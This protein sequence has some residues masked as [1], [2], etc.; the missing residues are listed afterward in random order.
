MKT[1]NIKISEIKEREDNPNKMNKSEMEALKKSIVKFG[2]LQPVLI[3]QENNLIDGHQRKKAYEELGK[4]EIPT[5]QLDLTEQSDKILLSQIMNKVKGSN[6]PELDIND[7]K[8]LLEDFGME[9][10]TDSLAVSEQEVLNLINSMNKEEKET[11]EQ[12]S[13]LGKH[14][15]ECPK[16]GHKFERED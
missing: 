15:I 4:K 13:Q 6:D 10:L 11:N 14:V 2:E 9:E 5:I 16:C 7:Y 3:D 1:I 8:K 12:V